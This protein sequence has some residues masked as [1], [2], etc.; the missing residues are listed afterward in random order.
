MAGPI[1]PKPPVKARAENV[2]AMAE[3]IFA[4]ELWSDRPEKVEEWLKANT[5][6]RPPR[7]PWWVPPPS[8]LYRGK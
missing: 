6:P 4:V 1:K 2:V 3:E 8:T 5:P 7:A